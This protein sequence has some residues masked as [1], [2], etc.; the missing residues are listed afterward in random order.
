MVA[1]CEQNRRVITRLLLREGRFNKPMA[2]QPEIKQAKQQIQL[3]PNYPTFAGQDEDEAS[4]CD[5]SQNSNAGVAPI[6]PDLILRLSGVSGY[7]EGLKRSFKGS[8]AAHEELEHTS[9]RSD[10][11]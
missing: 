2:D 4:W 11:I 8:Y 3:K 5:E 10:K 9:M 1:E 7:V 6:F